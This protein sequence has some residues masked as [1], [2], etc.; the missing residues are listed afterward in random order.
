MDG[1]TRT[2]DWQAAGMTQT[3]VRPPRT[4]EASFNGDGSNAPSERDPLPPGRALSKRAFDLTVSIAVLLL[5]TPALA[6]IALVVRVDSRGPVFFRCRRVGFRGR[7]LHMLK[8][9]KMHDR[10]TGPELTTHGDERFTRAGKWLAKLK[11]DELPQFVNVLRGEMSLVG[12]RPESYDF[13]GHHPEDFEEITRV[14][15]GIMGLSQLAFAEES[16]ILDD[17]DPLGHYVDHILPQKVALDLLYAERWSFLLDIRI[18]F[19]TVAAVG[20]RRQVAVNRQTGR[21]SLRRR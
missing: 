12:P 16:A 20:L 15:P 5:L 1:R 13:V 9:R 2:A 14:K 8:F 11:A 21:M 19:W 18:A 7:P 17:E 10:A 3:L 4:P 6:L